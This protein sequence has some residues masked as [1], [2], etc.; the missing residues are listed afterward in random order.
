M[1]G[2][3]SLIWDSRQLRSLFQSYEVLDN[4]SRPFLGD[5]SERNSQLRES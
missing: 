3:P 2:P 1:L 4:N 5:K